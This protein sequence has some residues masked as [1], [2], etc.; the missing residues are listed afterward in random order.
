[1]AKLTTHVLDTLRGEPAG[2]MRVDLYRDGKRAAFAVLNADG[3]C[4]PP[5]LEDGEL[6]PGVYEL[7]FHVRAYYGERG[8]ACPFLDVVP[9]RFEIEAGRSYHVPLVCTPWSYSTYRGS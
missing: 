2:G 1:M 8:D 9:V 5:L 7:Q 6:V 3:R 4:D